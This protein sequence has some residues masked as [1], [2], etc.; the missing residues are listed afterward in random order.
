MSAFAS[1]L[2]LSLCQVES[3]GKKNEITTMKEV[4]KL[5]FLKGCIVSTDTMG[6]QK[7]IAMLIKEQEGEYFLGLKDN[8]KTL[9]EE[10]KG[11]FEGQKVDSHYNR[12]D[13]QGSNTVVYQAHVIHQLALLD[14]APKWT[15]LS[16]IIH[17]NSKITNTLGVITDYNRYYISSIKYLT[18]QKA[19]TLARN[20]W[21]IE[22]KLHRSGDPV[23]LGHHL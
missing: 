3:S 1:D 8:Q 23:A 21:G 6:C 13:I 7:E 4:I 12:N 22:N 9:A 11:L 20:H 5:L 17:I 10:V 18:A 16:S 19:Y 14:E 2:G 15:D